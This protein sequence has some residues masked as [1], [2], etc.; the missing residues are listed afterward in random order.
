MLAGRGIAVSSETVR[1]WARRF[2]QAFADWKS[3][4]GQ[5]ITPDGLNRVLKAA[6][7]GFALLTALYS[8]ITTADDIIGVAIADAVS[9]RYHSGTNWTFMNDQVQPN[10]YIQMD[11]RN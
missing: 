3:A 10:G 9:G 1:R 8:V 7:S 5:K 6:Q 11:I 4:Q 2:G